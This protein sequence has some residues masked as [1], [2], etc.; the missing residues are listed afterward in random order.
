[1]PR[2]GS[3]LTVSLVFLD[4]ALNSSGFTSAI[5]P[6]H[7]SKNSKAATVSSL[8][9]DSPHQHNSSIDTMGST[10][11]SPSPPP[12]TKKQRLK[13]EK[14]DRSLGKKKAEVQFEKQLLHPSFLQFHPARPEIISTAEQ[15][16]STNRQQQ[17]TLMPGT[18]KHLGGAYDPNDGCIYGVPANSKTILCMYPIKDEASKNIQYRLKSIPLPDHV[19][20]RTFKWLRGIVAHGNLWAIP[21]WADHVLCVDLEA[22]RRSEDGIV[23]LIDLPSDH[24]SQTWQWHGAGINH[25]KTAIYCIPSNA[26]QVL[27][28]DIV[29]KTT[30]LIPIEGFD[31]KLYPN[32]DIT[33]TNKW[34]GGIVGA[35]N[36]VYGIPYRACAVLKIDCERNTATIIGN[37]YGA[38]QFNWHGGI[39][40][41]GKI[42][43]HPSHADTV[44]VIDTN[45]KDD[46]KLYEIPIDRT[47]SDP[48]KTYKWLG[49]SVGA[50]GNI[51]CPACDT[52]AVLKIDVPTDT[53][54]T[55]GFT[56][57]D[58]NKW[59][60]GVLARDGCIYCIPASG[61]HVCRILTQP[62]QPNVVQLLG[63]LPVTKDKWQ[64]SHSGLDGCLY[65]VPENGYR[66]LKV[67]PPMEPPEVQDGK[68]PNNDVK[69]DFL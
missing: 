54:T 51:Y 53:C 38:A 57:H 68:L 45:A 10:T 60:G 33:A 2:N 6:R 37:D 27:K 25:E 52:S 36:C 42:Y 12:L 3:A 16:E 22:H 15:Y 50:D 24:V 63:D 11:S 55:F 47:D 7:L 34:Y 67:T 35:D 43:A 58:K 49:G 18:H 44:L 59:Q 56:G 41:H 48:C 66:V 1:M 8:Q 61:K 13:Q 19:T 14:I 32:F 46:T 23:Q 9:L 17:A 31:P 30:S 20:N 4:L 40:V 69:L 26:H 62:G 29:T 5:H 64:G 21:S 65:F 39:Q 28:V